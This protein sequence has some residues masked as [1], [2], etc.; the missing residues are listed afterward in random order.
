MDLWKNPLGLGEK[1]AAR[2]TPV[3]VGGLVNGALMNFVIRR[4]GNEEHGEWHSVE[5][6]DRNAN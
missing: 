1:L 2:S 5:V 3:D 4:T 6:E